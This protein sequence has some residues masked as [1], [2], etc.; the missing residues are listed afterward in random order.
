MSARQAFIGLGSNLGD[1]GATL[2]RAI[3]VLAREPAIAV[4]ECSSVY[5]TK[6]VGVTDQPLFLNRVILVATTLSAE[7]LLRL[8]QRVEQ[9]S[10]RVRDVRWGPRTLDLDLLVF[11]GERC[12]TAALTLPHPRMLERAFVVVP[13]RELLARPSVSTT[14]WNDLRAGLPARLPDEDDV[15]HWEPGEGASRAPEV[16]NEPAC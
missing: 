16:G 7:G 9:E 1:R 4:L 10:G 5:E 13:L 11:E 6:P 14:V 2:Q 8:L 15:R 3:D 12:S